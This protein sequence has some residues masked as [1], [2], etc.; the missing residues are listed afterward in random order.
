MV[1]FCEQIC[2]TVILIIIAIVINNIYF[3]NN[4]EHMATNSEA[5][6]MLASLYNI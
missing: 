4:I 2:C 6:S 1:S 5:I 3:T